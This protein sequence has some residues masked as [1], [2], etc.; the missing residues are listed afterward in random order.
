MQLP[1]GP[2]PGSQC[3]QV[4]VG[5]IFVHG[6]DLAT[7]TGQQMAPD[8]GVAEAVLGTEWPSMCA[9]V[10][11][12]HPSIFAPEI[13][14]PNDAPAMDRLVGFLGRDPSWTGAA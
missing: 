4:A 2:A 11:N 9:D 14:V 8:Q 13:P 3:I 1:T 6:W 10:R 5:E 7:A 12:A